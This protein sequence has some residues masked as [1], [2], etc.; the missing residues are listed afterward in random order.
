MK[1]MC[2]LWRS[3]KSRLT[4]T[5]KNGEPVTEKAAEVLSVGIQFTPQNNACNLLD[6]T[7]SGEIVAEGRWS[8]SDPDCLVHHLRLGP[9]AMRVWVDVLKKPGVY[10]WRPTSDMATIEEAIGTTIAWP[11]DKVL[12]R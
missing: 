1:E 3:S 6:W 10:L 4:H 2:E 8:S 12:M 11:A 9:H 7:G 5:K